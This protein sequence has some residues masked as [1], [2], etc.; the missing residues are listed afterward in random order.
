LEFEGFLMRVLRG[1]WG[2]IFRSEQK[3]KKLQKVSRIQAN[4]ANL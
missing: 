4:L 2:W 3:T 1:I